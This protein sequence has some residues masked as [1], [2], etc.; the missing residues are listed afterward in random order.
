MSLFEKDKLLFSFLMALKLM[1]NDETI[2]QKEI[3]FLMTGGV[4]TESKKPMPEVTSSDIKIWFNKIVWTKIEELD[5]TI[6]HVHG[7]IA[8]KFSSNLKE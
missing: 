5:D 1:E 3:R 7:K 8:T 4:R 2:S 6:E